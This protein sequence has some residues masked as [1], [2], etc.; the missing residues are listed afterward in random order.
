LGL[1]AQAKSCIAA[2]R[3]IESKVK[4]W[5]V[6]PRRDL[7]RNRETD[8]AYLAAK[9]GQAYIL[10]FTAGGSGSVGLDL[11]DHAN[12]DFD[13]GW[14]DIGSGEWGATA[15]VSGGSTV[16]INRPGSGHWAAAIVRYS[17]P[18]GKR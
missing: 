18:A 7:L 10:Y 9:P 4:F 16:T 5:D 12:E 2:I 6:E 14:V 3:K 8:E 17:E 11:T 13:L 15:T 1:T